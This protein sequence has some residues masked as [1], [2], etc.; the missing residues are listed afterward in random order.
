MLDNLTIKVKVLLA[1]AGILTVTTL[2]GTFSLWRLQNINAASMVLSDDALPS[3][4][5]LSEMNVDVLRI[6]S[7][8]FQ[9]VIARD[10]AERQEIETRIDGFLKS[11]DADKAKYEP[12]ISSRE[13]QEIYRRFNEKWQRYISLWP[14][15]LD[16]SRKNQDEQA[17]DFMKES[18]SPIY[19]DAQTDLEALV[20]L[21]TKSAG[22]AA[23]DIN[24][25]ISS[26]QIGIGIALVT[27]ILIAISAGWSLI[28]GVVRPMGGLTDIMMRLARRDLTVAIPGVARRDELG[29]MARAVEVFKG[30]LIEA[31]RLAEAQKA[32][33]AAKERRATL[34]AEMIRGFDSEASAVLRAVSAAATELDATA[35][36]MSTIAEETNR[37]ATAAA[38]AAEQT[39]ANV[40]TVAAAAEEMAASIQEINH[41][42]NRS[43]AISDKAYTEVRHTDETVAGLAEAAGRIGAVVQ[44]IQDIA[45]QTNLL[46][47]NATIEAA[48]AGEAGKGFAVVASEVKALANQTSRATEEIA[49]QVASVQQATDSSVSAIRSI[50]TTIQSVSEIGASIAAAMEQQGASTSEIS[51]NVTQAATGTQEMSANVSQVTEAAAQTGTS[52]HQV[53]GAARE[54]AQ[55]SEQLRGQVEKFLAD[56]RAA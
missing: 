27:A 23:D 52:A 53:L 16:L 2:L 13:E 3:V 32:E 51:R 26:S 4:R 17:G 39:T 11:L 10:A 38:A 19:R 31:D 15:T 30:G 46:A 20:E 12:F 48:R 56:I 5:Y 44:L 36:S 34:I 35:Q 40:Q 21:N 1:F 18:M 33:Q 54:L 24:R 7:A 9:H 41:Q 25:T 28:T 55:Q 8:Q 43:K 37:Q 49:A 45:G 14:T 42:V 47:L 22:I 50:G 6:R 29:E